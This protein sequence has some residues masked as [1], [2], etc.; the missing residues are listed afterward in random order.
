MIPLNINLL[1]KNIIAKKGIEG[2]K[3]RVLYVLGKGRI[4]E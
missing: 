2:G 3:G 4:F 1:V